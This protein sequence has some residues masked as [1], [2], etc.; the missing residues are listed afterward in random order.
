MKTKYFLIY[1]LVGAAFLGVSAWVYFTRGKNVK[2]LRAKYKLGGIMLTCL[3]MLSVASCDGLRPWVTCYDAVIEERTEDIISISIEA[4]DP[5]YEHNEMS[6]GDKFC[7]VID[8]PTYD[9]YVLKVILNDEEGTELQREEL[10]VGYDD[11]NEFE[12]V[13]SQDITYKGKAIVQIHGVV[14]ESPEELTL[15]AYGIQIFSIR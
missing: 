7:V 4:S 5:S 6:P 3:A 10:V 12:V 15:M 11:H 13:L 1:I 14:S 9:K 2:A 8:L